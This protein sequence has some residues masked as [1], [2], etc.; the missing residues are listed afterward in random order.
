MPDVKFYVFDNFTKQGNFEQRWVKAKSGSHPNI[1]VLEQLL[2]KDEKQLLAYETKCLEAG[3]EGLILRDPDGLYKFG[4]STLKE[5]W[6]LK[7]KNFVD[8]EYEIIGFEE[9]M[10]NGNEAT[11]NELGRT[12]RS[13]AAAGKVGRGDLGSLILRGE[14]FTFNVGTGF[15][16]ALRGIIW[17]NREKILGKFA[18]VKHF[19]IGGKEAPRFPVFLGFREQWDLS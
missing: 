19:P 1:I 4:R 8:N 10:H 15:D 2:I 12:K 9:R 18:K 11:T 5:G 16:D 7:M 6:M 3:Y 17:K 13:S 14:G